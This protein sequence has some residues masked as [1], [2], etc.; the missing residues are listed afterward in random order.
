MENTSLS[1][2]AYVEIRQRLRDG[3][4]KPGM[5]L[6]NRSVAAEL[7]ISTIPVREA[8]SRLV[9]EGLLAAAP[10]AGA[11]VRQADAE[12]LNELYD[13][14]TALEV[15]A[16]G[17]AARYAN[18]HLL[19]DLKGICG[20]LAAIAKAIPANRNATPAQLGDWLEGEIAFHSRVVRASRNRWLVKVTG[21]LGV[22][23]QIFTMR[24]T[25][26]KVL[27]G[28]LA[29][30]TQ[31]Q[32]E[33]LIDILARHDVEGARAWMAEHIRR[34]RTVVLGH[35]ALGKPVESSQVMP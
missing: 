10:G 6:V 23:S 27:T 35:L 15:L 13:V 12:E 3:S 31:R 5:R 33:E 1:Q 9:S 21:D 8:I 18:E 29:T 22:I 30:A 11:Y 14:R 17:E 34:G 2:R 32:H 26:P 7:G 19:A 4:L 20:H 16:A 25:P 24:Q 28:K